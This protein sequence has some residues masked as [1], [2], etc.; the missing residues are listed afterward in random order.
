[1]NLAANKEDIYQRID[2]L[3]RERNALARQREQLRAIELQQLA[4]AFA[5]QL[6]DAGLTV[7]EGIAALRPHTI[8]RSGTNGGDIAH[9]DRTH[10]VIRP[11]PYV[12][13]PKSAP[14]PAMDD[15]H[16]K[17]QDLLGRGAAAWL[18]SPHALLGGASPLDMASTARGKHKVMALLDAYANA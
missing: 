13:A 12:T 14:R 8:L 4:E 9:R 5:A 10:S 3:T 16:I 7:D 2:R 6:A 17:A 18:Q 15:V 1:M 11:G